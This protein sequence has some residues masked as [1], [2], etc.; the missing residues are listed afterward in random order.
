MFYI[1]AA[2]TIG[3]SLDKAIALRSKIALIVT[4]DNFT[5]I[6]MSA[7]VQGGK[8]ARLI[9]QIASIAFWAVYYCLAIVGKFGYELGKLYG[10]DRYRVRTAALAIEAEEL[11]PVVMV[12]GCDR[13]HWRQCPAGA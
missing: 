13:R 3:T 9:W 12:R 11:A 8:V 1:S 6:A 2:N 10:V 5:A 7:T 4:Y